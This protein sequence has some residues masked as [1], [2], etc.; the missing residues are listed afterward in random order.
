MKRKKKKLNHQGSPFQSLKIAYLGKAQSMA[1]SG[2]CLERAFLHIVPR[3]HLQLDERLNRCGPHR[4]SCGSGLLPHSLHPKKGKDTVKMTQTIS[5]SQVLLLL[6]LFCLFFDFLF[7]AS[8]TSCP[9]KSEAC[10]S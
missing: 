10:S 5:I 3:L 2:G 4:T 7:L 9:R 1:V 6:L 8:A